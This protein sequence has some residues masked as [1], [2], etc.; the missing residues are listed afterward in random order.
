MP[1]LRDLKHAFFYLSRGEFKELLYRLRVHFGPLDLRNTMR[2][3][4]QP[5]PEGTYTYRHSG[6]AQLKRVFD[7]LDIG[8][9]DAIVDLGAGKGGA[10]IEFASYPFGK[11]AGVELLPELAVI[12]RKNFRKAKL[13]R[14]DMLVGDAAEFTDLDGYNYFY[15]YN[16]F[17]Q[18]VMEQVMRNI[19]AS[20]LKAPRP[21]T[22]IYY[23][24]GFHQTVIEHSPFRQTEYFEDRL[25]TLPINV[26]RYAP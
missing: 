22:L 5:S 8:P 4:L 24:P 9:D 21:S 7:G 13:E 11:I 10:L 3:D 14:I 6:G 1:L 20:L 23:S 26:Y 12:A 2:P 25:Q 17:P 15:F 18:P 16:P 19:S